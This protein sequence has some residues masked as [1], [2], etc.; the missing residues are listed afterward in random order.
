[1]GYSLRFTL[2]AAALLAAGAAGVA[3]AQ[4]GLA[5]E[6]AGLGIKP[7]T[8]APEP[9]L[10]GGD[11]VAIWQGSRTSD[12]SLY[13]GAREQPRLGM[14]E[15]GMYSGIVQPLTA[16]FG[17]SLEAGYVQESL[18]APRR[19]V[20][21]GQLHTEF[22]DGRA[23]SLGLQYRVYDGD[24][25]SRAIAPGDMSTLNGY[26]LASSRFPGAGYSPGYQLQLGYQH[27]PASTFGLAFGREVET[28]APSFDSVGQR[29]LTFTGQHWLTS[30]WAVSYDV[31]TYDLAS[32]MRPQNLRLGLG[33]RYRF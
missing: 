19:Y 9:L 29:Q 6:R 33:M 18:L 2:I 1:M 22:R 21:T 25:N 27:S 17:S 10:F 24:L 14:N 5:S 8:P 28:Y 4:A 32:P 23:L 13:A 16:S 3:S 15:T 26:S 31:L 11:A 7:G 12:Y 30:S 20:F